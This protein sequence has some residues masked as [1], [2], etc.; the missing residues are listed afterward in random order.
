[1]TINDYYFQALKRDLGIDGMDNDTI[2]YDDAQE[3]DDGILPGQSELRYGKD[4][5]RDLPSSSSV[6]REPEW[7]DDPGIERVFSKWIAGSPIAPTSLEAN[8]I[9]QGWKGGGV[10]PP[11]FQAVA[12]QD[13]YETAN[14]MQPQDGPGLVFEPG[15]LES[16]R[17]GPSVSNSQDVHFLDLEQAVSDAFENIRDLDFEPTHHQGPPLDYKSEDGLQ[18]SLE[19][20][21]YGFDLETEIS[22]P[23]A[24]YGDHST[25]ADLEGILSQYSHLDE[26]DVAR[27]LV[28]SRYIEGL[29]FDY[30]GD[31]PQSI[32]SEGQLEHDVGNTPDDHISHTSYL[33]LTSPQWSGDF[34]S[35]DS[36][37]DL[38][39]KGL[40]AVV[41]S[42]DNQESPV[43][44]ITGPSS[45]PRELADPSG[46]NESISIAQ[47][48]SNAQ[49]ISPLQNHLPDSGP[50]SLP[51]PDPTPI[52][53]VP[54]PQSVR[55][56]LSVLS[57][58]PKLF[59]KPTEVVSRHG[60]S[61]PPM[62][63][64]ANLISPPDP[65]QIPSPQIGHPLTYGP[66]QVV[67][68][69][70]P[71]LAYPV[72]LPPG[73]AL[74]PQHSTPIYA[75][76][77]AYLVPANYPMYQVPQIPGSLIAHFP[78]EATSGPNSGPRPGFA[79][80]PPESSAGE[81]QIGPSSSTVSGTGDDHGIQS[82]V[83]SNEP[84]SEV[85]QF[86][87][88]LD[89]VFRENNTD[90]SKKPGD[91]EGVGPG[92]RQLEPPST[93]NTANISRGD[94]SFGNQ[95]RPTIGS[96][97][98]R[99]KDEPKPQLVEAKLE[100]SPYLDSQIAENTNLLPDQDPFVVLAA[101][102]YI[103]EFSDPFTVNIESANER[104]GADPWDAPRRTSTRNPRM[105]TMVSGQMG[106]DESAT[107]SVDDDIV[108][109]GSMDLYSWSRQIPVVDVED[110]PEPKRFFEARE[111]MR[112]NGW[113]VIEDGNDILPAFHAKTKRRRF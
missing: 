86:R 55:S 105:Y 82:P 91:Q 23:G 63:P 22:A 61:D 68:P 9:S 107:V 46:D 37:E 27:G 13:I 69:Q 96:L 11:K 108:D 111:P 28:D 7:S 34:D 45:D 26:V 3:L 25:L 50:A 56:R 21:R 109:R 58:L 94:G 99:K 77:M 48:T 10:F 57:R 51:L 8:F 19:A 6:N 15:D 103:V 81:A 88:P 92:G 29:S 90:P 97:F 30:Y 67:V 79:P 54:T 85:N 40:E 93:S 95:S 18:G 36:E 32:E 60:L 16:L 53:S 84:G 2:F 75:M 52:K 62:D 39:Q 78:S 113:M 64:W 59:S 31:T 65:T 1:M 24:D 73:P 17:G 12:E 43:E 66:D 98:R 33:G 71:S 4:D 14:S 70:Q 76:P 106:I 42:W 72:G 80:M 49:D 41:I 47:A 101:D 100:V 112:V 44:D 5:W 87:S 83:G 20:D 74:V 110:E 38:G 104:I 102:T 89:E 35:E